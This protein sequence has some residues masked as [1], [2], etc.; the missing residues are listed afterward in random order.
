AG[1][2]LHKL[3]K[4]NIAQKQ[5][6]PISMMP[7][8]LTAS[9]REDE[10]IDLVRFLSELGK[11]G[12]YKVKP[13]RFIRTWRV[14]GTMEQLDVDHV[15]HTG[16]QALSDRAHAYPWQPGY[17]LVNGAFPLNE[18]TAPVK[19]Y[20]WFPKILQCDLQMESAGKIKLKL[21]TSR[22]VIVTVSDKV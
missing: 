18:A 20:P 16:L 3:P 8:G 10:F 1:N 11:E 14:M 12:D 2:Q 19:M 13:N 4:T 17:S 7:P 21:S 5:L 22:N 9:L 15:R 6:S